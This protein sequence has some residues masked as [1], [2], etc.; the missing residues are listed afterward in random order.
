MEAASAGL[1]VDRIAMYEVP[2]SVGEESA[3]RWREYVVQLRAA[4]ARG[5]RGDAIELFMRLAGA[6]EEEVAGAR[7]SSYWPGLEA[8]AHT[9]AY[10]AACLGDDGRPPVARLATIAQPALV[11]TGARAADPTMP[12]MAPDFFDLA[13]DAIV[14]ALPRAE[15]VVIEGQGHVVDPK[16]LAPILE[17]FVGTG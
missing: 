15:R 10:D 11:S 6:S 3:R 2:Y 12:G 7:T 16:A 4:F 8:L 14:A 17:R 9:L 1:A 5:R 13:A